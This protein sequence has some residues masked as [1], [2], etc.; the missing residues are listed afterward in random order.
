MSN[1][2]FITFVVNK[3]LKT[4]HII[5]YSPKSCVHAPLYWRN[6]VNSSTLLPPSAI[7]TTKLL[8]KTNHLHST[9][10]FDCISLY[11]LQS[12][13]QTTRTSVQTKPQWL[14]G[15]KLLLKRHYV[16]EFQ[17]QDT[18]KRGKTQ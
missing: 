14:S 5:Q 18:P 11:K 9:T 6:N 1:F 8:L 12:M 2:E 4:R 10:I 16:T 13:A 3:D 7:S 15:L 17:I